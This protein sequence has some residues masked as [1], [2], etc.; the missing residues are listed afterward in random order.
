MLDL[1]TL[2]LLREVVIFLTLWGPS[3][4]YEQSLER[5]W[6]MGPPRRTEPR[7]GILTPQQLQQE[8]TNNNAVSPRTPRVHPDLPY[9]LRCYPFLNLPGVTRPGARRDK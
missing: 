4:R 9:P 1:L 8:S 2:Y 3:K 5:P 6:D 7:D